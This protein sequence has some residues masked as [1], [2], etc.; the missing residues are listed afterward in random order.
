MVY[1]TGDLHGRCEK[2][3]RFIFDMRPKATDTFI[4][5]GDVGANYYSGKKDKAFKE[6]LE[7]HKIDML[8]IHGNHE[9][10]P[11]NIST[12]KTKVWNGGL[13]WYEDEYPHLL[14]AKDGEIYTIEGKRYFVIGGAYSVDKFYRIER[15]YAWWE[16]EQPS[17]EIKRYVEEQA[18]K[19]QS[20]DFVL[21]HTCP[22]KYVPHETFLS[23][24][25]QSTVD[26]S[27]EIWLDKIEEALNYT[28]WF[29]GH[30]HIEKR[31]D[32]IH[33]I[34]DKFEVVENG[35]AFG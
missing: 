29:C 16:D 17:D 25:D 20:V 35:E 2:I 1:I 23:F 31:I 10:R 19:V 13:V 33:F 34:F 27:T 11:Q 3:E 9:N 15:H 22:L 24:I 14:F 8:C 21:T 12:Y 18:E 28:A 32:K 26:N 4:I 5:L 7:R 30:W 6:L